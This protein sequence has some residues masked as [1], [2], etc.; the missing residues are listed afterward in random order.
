M[1]NAVARTGRGRSPSPNRSPSGTSICGRR[2]PSALT[3]SDRPASVSALKGSTWKCRW[4]S[5]P[6]PRSRASRVMVPAPSRRRTDRSGR[7]AGAA[8]ARASDAAAAPASSPRNGATGV[9]PGAA[10]SVNWYQLDASPGTLVTR[11]FSDRAKQ[12]GT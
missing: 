7:P 12:N 11:T 2:A 3:R 5:V 6:A 8:P 4:R 1:P 9:S 10:S